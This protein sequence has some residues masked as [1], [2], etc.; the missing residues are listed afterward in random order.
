MQFARNSTEPY[1]ILHYRSSFRGD[2]DIHLFPK[3]GT[4]RCLTL[5]LC[6]F[7]IWHSASCYKI[8]CASNLAALKHKV[9]QELKIINQYNGSAK[10][11][12][13]PLFNA[14]VWLTP[15][16]RVPCSNAAETQNPLNFAGMPHTRQQI[17]AVS[18]T[19]FTILSGHVEEALLIN[20][21][22]LLIVDTCPSSEDIA[23][24][25]CAMVPKWQLFACCISSEP[26]APCSTFQTCIPIRTRAT[27][28]VEVW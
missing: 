11:R 3:T 22:F 1:I 26:C 4:T 16:T 19:K 8:V 2:N 25:S 18:R 23:R 24:Q 6:H 12:W 10:Y 17:S 9:T 27:P 14:A 13:R 7:D 28:C 15:T 5:C 20:K 21:F